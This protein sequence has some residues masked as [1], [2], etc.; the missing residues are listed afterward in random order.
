MQDADLAS[1]VADAPYG[2]PSVDLPD[3][4]LAAPRATSWVAGLA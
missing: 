1:T 3:S 4:R 2:D